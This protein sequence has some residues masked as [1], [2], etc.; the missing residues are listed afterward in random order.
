MT[1]FIALPLC[2]ERAGF[3]AY[4]H[5]QIYL[6]TML[7][8]FVSVVPG[9]IIAETKRKMKAVFLCCIVILIAAEATLWWADNQLWVL[10]FGTLLFLS[11]LILWKHCFHPLLV[12]KRRQEVKA[13]R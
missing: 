3:P 6:V 12:K 8:A 1:T 9:I 10:I 5:W 4:R 2:F 7:I 13:Q 11:A